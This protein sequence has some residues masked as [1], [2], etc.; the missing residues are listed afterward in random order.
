MERKTFAAIMGLIIAVFFAAS[1]ELKGECRQLEENVLRLHILAE[2]DSERDQSLKLMVRDALL[3]KSEDIFGG[4]DSMEEMIACA[5]ENSE[6]ITETAEN[7]LRENG[8]DAKVSAKVEKI[9][10]DKRVYGDIT[11]PEGD[12]TALRVVIGSGGGHNWW[13]VMFPPLCIP[14]FTGE[15]TEDEMLE[16]YDCVITEEQAEMLRSGDEYEIRFY[17]GELLEKLV[18]S[19]G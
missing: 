8:C 15:M 18:E 6:L 12:Y 14:C 7:V 13:C 9:H 4:A 16:K 5:E 17:F 2:S 10:F 1:A 3:E 19:F 11:M